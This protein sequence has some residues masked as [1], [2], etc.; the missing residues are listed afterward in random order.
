[1]SDD[2]LLQAIRERTA[3]LERDLR[4]GETK[5]ANGDGSS[6]LNGGSDDE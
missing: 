5:P 2:E 6:A 3:A 4:D 1:M